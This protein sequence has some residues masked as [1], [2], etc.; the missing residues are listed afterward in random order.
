MIEFYMSKKFVADFIFIMKLKIRK[1][2]YKLKQ[3]KIIQILFIK[4][5]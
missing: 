4:L 3:I 5:Y 2:K 1:V